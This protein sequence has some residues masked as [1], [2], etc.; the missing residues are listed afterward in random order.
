MALQH[1]RMD[2][3]AH[4]PRRRRGAR[5][6]TIIAA[7]REFGGG[8][9]RCTHSCLGGRGERSDERKRRGRG[10]E[11][12]EGEG[13]QVEGDRTEADFAVRRDKGVAS[14]GEGA[15]AKTR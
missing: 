12:K 15:R 10:G 13:G 1:T 2:E 11:E 3:S 5:H 7:R 4:A 6:Q 9:R 14:R 8:E